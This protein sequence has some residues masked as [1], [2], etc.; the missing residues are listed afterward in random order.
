MLNRICIS[1][2][3]C[4][5]AYVSLGCHSLKA[6]LITLFDGNGLPANQP[7]LAYAN[8]GGTTTQTGQ[9]SGVRLVT[10][11]AASAGYSNYTPLGILKNGTFPSLNR[12][13]GFEL[14]FNVAV[15]SE[16]H[17]TN[18]RAGFSITLLGSDRRGIE[19]GFW[20]DQIWAQ[21]DSPLFTHG[22]IVNFD[23]SVQRDYRLRVLENS[24]SLFS[25][26]DQLLT[27]SVRNYTAFGAPPYI[28]PNFVFLGDNTSSAGADI[29]LGAITLQSNLAAVPEPS[30]LFLLLATSTLVVWRKVLVRRRFS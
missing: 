26:D 30:S 18:D 5:L 19:L 8:S 10:D 9:T 23:T 24:Y 22:E 3:H 13:N 29:S 16:N 28:L 6:E 20:R 17:S 14:N 27:G 15:S 2:L 7:W 4:T 21:A 11:L 12:T 1:L 25:G